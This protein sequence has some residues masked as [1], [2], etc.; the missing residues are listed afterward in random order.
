LEVLAAMIEAHGKS[1]DV[2][3]GSERSF[4]FVFAAV[5]AI[6]GCWP[7]ISS[8][9]PRWW[10]L[11]IAVAFLPVAL[12]RPGVLRPLNI[13]WFKFGLLLSRIVTPVVMALVYVLTIIPTGLIMRLR[14]KNLLDLNP[15]PNK[16]SY[17][18]VRERPGPGP[19]TMKRQ[20]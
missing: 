3:M 9:T 15:T 5:F 10:A 6:I 11:A 19:D 16:T 7:L 8:E 14:R 18:V 13:L 1:D 4:G 20:F 2:E 12:V 17:W